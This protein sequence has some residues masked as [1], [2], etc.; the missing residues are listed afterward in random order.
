MSYTKDSGNGVHIYCKKMNMNGCHLDMVVSVLRVLSIWIS[1]FENK[2]LPEK[3][4][5]FEYNSN[6]HPGHLYILPSSWHFPLL[7]PKALNLCRQYLPLTWALCYLLPDLGSGLNSVVSV[8]QELWVAF[9]TKKGLTVCLK[10]HPETNKPS[11]T[12]EG[13]GAD[14]SECLGFRKQRQSL[15]F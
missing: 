5:M 2:N 4:N 10:V 1:S 7:F 9:N 12:S 13:N 8:T 14:S 3:P 15:W 11:K 6:F